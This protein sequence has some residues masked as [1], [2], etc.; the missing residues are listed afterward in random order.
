M[1]INN[2]LKKE[3]EDAKREI[4]R[5][6]SNFDIEKW[7]NKNGIQCNIFSYDNLNDKMKLTDLFSRDGCCII[8]Y[9][10]KNQN[11]GHWCAIIRHDRDTI[12]FFDPYGSKLDSNLKYSENKFPT[13]TSIFKR[14][15]VKNVIFNNMRLQRMNNNIST[16]G[17][18]CSFRILNK[19]LT[20][21][22]YQNGFLKSGFPSKLYDYYIYLLTSDI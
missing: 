10:I 3:Y 1:V 15:K 6:L 13:I 8:L 4:A 22:Q 14:H 18:H 12:E 7:L 20:L 21:E 19:D 11:T 9:N 2:D 5:P 16:C 17:R